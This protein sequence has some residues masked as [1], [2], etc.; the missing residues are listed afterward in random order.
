[1]S[2][3][4]GVRLKRVAIPEGL[5]PENAGFGFG[6]N[7]SRKESELSDICERVGLARLDHFIVDHCALVE[8]AMRA[9]GWAELKTDSEC[10]AAVARIEEE[11]ERGKPWFDPAD[12]LRTVR[13]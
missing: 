7:I 11:V 12:G 10:H 1:M 8:Q 9:S 13:G 2:T 4:M 5:I 3:W 6:Q